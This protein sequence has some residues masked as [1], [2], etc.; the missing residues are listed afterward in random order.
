MIVMVVIYA[1]CWLPLHCVT[2]I[3][4]LQP[5]IW[6]FDGIQ[7]VWIACHWLA[8]SSCCWNPVVY[9][10]TND[11]LRAGFTYALGSWCPCV[12]QSTTPPN[13]AC[14]RQVVYQSPLRHSLRGDGGGHLHADGDVK[15]TAFLVRQSSA[16]LHHHHRARR[17]ISGRSYNIELRQLRASPSAERTVQSSPVAR[18]ATRCY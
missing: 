2:V 11:T 16:R 8:V 4:D 9:Y 7:L 1:L 15:R 6:N 13:T 3:G 14:R 17:T 12:R 10:W 18:V 5:T